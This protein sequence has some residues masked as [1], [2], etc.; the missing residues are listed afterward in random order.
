MITQYAVFYF[1]LIMPNIKKTVLPWV[2]AMAMFIDTLDST[3]VGVAIPAIADNFQVNPVDMKLAL[4][5]YLLS[6]SIF[7]PISGWLA[8]RFGEKKILIAAMLLFTACSLLC[9]LSPNLIFLII[10][11][12]L[13]GIGGALMMPVGRLIMLRSFSKAEFNKAMS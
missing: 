10:A 9:A 6:L 11:R 8:D 12:I 7:I 5:G 3:I 13:Q 4:T 2:I 1:A